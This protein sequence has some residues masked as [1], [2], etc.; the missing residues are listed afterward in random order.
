MSLADEQSQECELISEYCKKAVN[1][2]GGFVLPRQGGRLT[3]SWQFSFLIKHKILCL[4]QNS[5]SVN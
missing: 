5:K 3:K 4:S 2:N 1:A